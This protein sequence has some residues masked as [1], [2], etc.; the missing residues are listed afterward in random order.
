MKKMLLIL[1]DMEYLGKNG[2]DFCQTCT[3]VISAGF[4]AEV[5]KCSTSYDS[6]E[7]TVEIL[8]SLFDLG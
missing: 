2:K 3:K 6:D 1:W 5:E 8:S 7:K 4:R